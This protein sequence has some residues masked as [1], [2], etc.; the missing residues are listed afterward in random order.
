MKTLPRI[1]PQSASDSPASQSGDRTA[2]TESRAPSPALPGSVLLGR[3]EVGPRLGAGGM[4]IVYEAVD[5]QLRA[6]VALKFLHRSDARALYRLK[7]EFRAMNVLAPHPNLIA[8]SGLFCEHGRWFVS[9]ELIRGEQL[10]QYMRPA[11]TLDVGRVRTALLQLALGLQAIHGAGKVH[12]DLKPS[13]VL[14]TVEGRLVIL[15]FGLVSDRDVD[16]EAAAR[17]GRSGTPRYMA[18][19]QARGEPATEASDAYMS[20]AECAQPDA[21]IEYRRRASEM[22]LCACYIDLGIDAMSPVLQSLGL[23][24]PRRPWRI[25]LAVLYDSLVVGLLRRRFRP[26]DEATIEKTELARIDACY[27]LGLAL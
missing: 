21:R 15:D 7:Q 9:M 1:A 14:V 22:Y 20:A 19:E 6:P 18:P 17:P 24:F 27:S 3:F 23:Q 8:P 4:G 2:T 16:G 11:Q 26:R 5:R 25:V 13:N 10:L 12:R